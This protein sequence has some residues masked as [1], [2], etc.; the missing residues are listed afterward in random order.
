MVNPP[1]ESFSPTGWAEGGGFDLL[2]AANEHRALMIEMGGGPVSEEAVDSALELAHKHVSVFAFRVDVYQGES[3]VKRSAVFRP[4]RK[5]WA[6]RL[7]CAETPRD[8]ETGIP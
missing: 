5:I 4:S 8:Q 7:R 6:E 2:Y 3:S 1:P